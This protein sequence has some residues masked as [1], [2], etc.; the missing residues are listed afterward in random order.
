MPTL[1]SNLFTPE[2]WAAAT[3]QA[4]AT[5]A[6]IFTS[7]VVRRLPEFDA[8]AS[9]GGV[10]ATVPVFAD[11]TDQSDEIQVE[12]AG[13]TTDNL[14]TASGMVG[15]FCSRQTKNSFTATAA[16]ISGVG[17]AED[18]ATV[19]L[20]QVIQRRL[21]Q[22]QTTMLH[23]LRGAFGTS[24]GAALG[25][26]APL[27]SMRI[28]AADESGNDATSG[29]TFSGDLFISAKAMLGELADAIQFGAFFCHPAIRAALEKADKDSFKSGVVSGL[30]YGITTYRGVPIF[31]SSL[32][33]RAG[34]TNGLVYDS[35][36][37]WPG[38]FGY[39][40]RPQVLDEVAVAALQSVP[41]FDLNVLK[42][43]DRTRFLLHLNGM[44]WVGTPVNPNGGPANV[45]LA[46]FTNWQ[47]ALSSAN[48]VGAVCIV[49]NG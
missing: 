10:N 30:P 22:R 43:I 41:D 13:P 2:R 39:G 44:K 49:T 11:I 15:V 1:V 48:R 46:A 12:N 17:R 18:L 4:Q 21:K 40:E 33:A 5:F 27:A 26:A 28:T 36:L 8:L 31:T 16:G 6:S 32:L 47:L 3:V 9:G 35:Y 7:G 45:E 19:V 23:M 14:I 20:E 37:V 38:R 42:V 34:T 29:Q 24:P 25:N